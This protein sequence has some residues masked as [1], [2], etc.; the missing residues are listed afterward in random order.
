MFPLRRA[1]RAIFGRKKAPAKRKR[2]Q[3]KGRRLAKQTGHLTVKKTEIES[4]VSV[5]AGATTYGVDTFEL[6]DLTQYTSYIALYE[7]FRID[8][9]VYSFKSL[10][11]QAVPPLSSGFTATLGM[12]HTQIDTNDGVAPT[13]IQGMMNDNSYRGT[14][15]SR[16]HTRVIYPK[17]MM[18]AGSAQ[19]KPTRGWLSCY[20]VDGVTV[21]AASHYGIKWALEGG[22]GGVGNVSFVVEPIIT[23]YI[24]F[25]NPR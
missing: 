2:V 16:N 20:N 11:N 6:A 24:S 12:I 18:N 8:K 19:N 22:L 9:I 1:Y 17:Y 3:R 13:S 4:R 7:E 5:L 15:S 10:V 21:N 23:Y 14:R 25:R